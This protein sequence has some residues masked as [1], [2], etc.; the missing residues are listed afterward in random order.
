M[1]RKAEAKIVRRKTARPA[2]PINA[3]TASETARGCLLRNLKSHFEEFLIEAKLHDLYLLDSIL[4]DF[5]SINRG[6]DSKAAES[7][8]AEAFMLALDSDDTYVKVPSDNVETVEKFLVML[9][10]SPQGKEP[11]SEPA[12]RPNL[13]VFPAREPRAEASHAS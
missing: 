3:K 8:L 6:P 7:P 1:S 12:G 10:D 13:V 9:D 5:A 11:A 4:M 2:T